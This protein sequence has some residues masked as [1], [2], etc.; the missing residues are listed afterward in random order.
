MK[1]IA[2]L[3]AVL[4]LSSVLTAQQLRFDD[5][6]R[7]LRNPDPKMR[8]SAVRLLRDAKYPEAVVPM[9]PLVLDPIDDVQLEAIAAELSFFLEQDVKSKKMVGFVLEKRKSVIAAA[10]FDFGPLAV[11]PRPVPAELVTALLQAVDDENAKVRLEAI[12]ATGVI[13]RGPLS[14]AQMPLLLKALDHYDPAVRTAA[15]RVIGRLKAAGAAD[16]LLKAV[17]DSQADVRYAAMRALGAV[18]DAR[19]TT[20]LT[21][22]LAF[23]KKGEGAWSALEALARLASPASTPLFKERLQDK[24][25][26]IRRAAS[27]GLGRAGDTESI[28]L[29]EGNVT[30]DDSA[31][32]RLA[33]AFALHKLG[34]NYA[35]RIVDL[36][37]SSKVRAQAQDY[38]IELGPATAPTI[39]P[40]IQDADND[41]REALIDV[42]GVVGDASHV[43]ALQAVSSDGDASVAAAAKR[44]I[45]RLQ[46]VGASF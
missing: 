17:N 30:S 44:A 21:E 39:L 28:E 26:F 18:G 38:L 16:A 31:M 25:P 29:L 11:W 43:A 35:G 10:A 19:A 9:A 45:A 36:M 7:N 42:L 46:G 37:T 27:E 4:G 24:D 8:L 20:A 41:L 6:V 3:V 15:A 1:K 33:A 2:C 34:R 32:V 22:Q 13:A 23:Y 5:V 14:A 12:Y 40:R